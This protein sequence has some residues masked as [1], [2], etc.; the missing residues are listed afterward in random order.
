MGVLRFVDAGTKALELEN[1]S[2]LNEPTTYAVRVAIDQAVYELITEGQRKGLWNYK[3]PEEKRN[4][5]KPATTNATPTTTS[6]TETKTETAKTETT[7]VT[8]MRLREASYIYREPNESSQR[9]WLLK[10]NT[11]LTVTSGQAGWVAVQDRAGRRGWVKSDRL[12]Q[13]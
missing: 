5:V 9:I 10:E 1:G 8:V 3:R 2:A 13:L 11:E 7:A 6:G 12:I 4:D